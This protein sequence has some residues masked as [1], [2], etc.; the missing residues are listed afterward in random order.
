MAPLVIG[1]AWIRCDLLFLFFWEYEDVIMMMMMIS[2][3]SQR[4]VVLEPPMR[5]KLRNDSKVLL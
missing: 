5:A 1:S 2:I 4:T 3:S